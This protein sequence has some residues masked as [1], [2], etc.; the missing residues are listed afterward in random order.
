MNRRTISTGLCIGRILIVVGAILLLF[1][2]WAS[3]AK[4]VR[5]VVEYDDGSRLT[6]TPDEVTLPAATQPAT[7]PIADAAGAIGSVVVVNDD[8]EKTLATFAADGKATIRITDGIPVYIDAK[9]TGNVDRVDFVFSDGSK[10]IE[11][12]APW[13]FGKHIAN[14]W[15]PR[16]GTYAFA[17]TPFFR[18]V[19]GVSRRLTLTINAPPVVVDPAPV[20][21]PG[22]SD[23]PLA[24]GAR[25]IFVSSNEGDDANA[26]TLQKP[27]KTLQRALSMMRDGRGDRV[28]PIAGSVFYGG[29]AWRFSGNDQGKAGIIAYGAGDRP[30][31]ESLTSAIAVGANVKSA[32]F[33]G[34]HL[35]PPNRD[36]N[37]A[38]F[39]RKAPRSV[40]ID[41]RA[42]GVEDIL[43]ED[44]KIE[45]FSTGTGGHTISA[46]AMN[47]RFAIRRNIIADSWDDYIFG[48]HG[49]FVANVDG[50]TIE[51][52]FFDRCG[53]PAHPN[54]TILPTI[55]RHDNY[56][57]HDNKNVRFAHNWVFRGASFGSQVRSGG[58]IEGNVYYDNG[59]AAL[60]SGDRGEFI[61]NVVL[62]GHAHRAAP[63]IG[64][65]HGGISANASINIVRDNFFWGFS[66]STVGGLTETVGAID[67]G[68]REWTPAGDM[69]FIFKGNNFIAWPED[70]FIRSGRRVEVDWSDNPRRPAPKRDDVWPDDARINSLRNRPRGVWP[71]SYTP[72][73]I[74]AAFGKAA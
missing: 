59:I 35:Y 21:A 25:E 15:K 16:A 45:W 44:N 32:A 61:G 31:I 42:D 29:I 9:T 54:L 28:R 22:F 43:I 66:K 10:S 49:I 68:R 34:L 19:A 63:I 69:S 50:L 58:V 14:G 4:P 7:Q 24:P 8:D 67:Y 36:P 71:K 3:G 64:T 55:Y 11:K 30:R 37:N 52:N 26:G 39:D 70:M 12:V 17:V 41:Y 46:G 40:G 6:F 20:P 48:G 74:R 38:K 72:Q 2:A 18:N 5:I 47:K 51:E 60:M 27:V 13:T 73:Q 56:I 33:V 62:G 65:G 1:A 23:L 57:Q 53:Q